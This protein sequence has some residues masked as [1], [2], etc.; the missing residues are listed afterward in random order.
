[1]LSVVKL[2]DKPS[3]ISF[4]RTILL[5]ALIAVGGSSAAIRD[6]DAQ[7]LPADNNKRATDTFLK[8][9]LEKNLDLTEID[10]LA[11]VARYE[12]QE[13]RSIPMP[14]GQSF[15]QK[16]WLIPVGDGEAP[17][18][19]TSSDVTNGPLRVLGCGIYG[20]QL[21]G[22]AM[23][24]ELSKLARMGQPTKH[25]QGPHGTTV[26]WSAQ[27][28]SRAPSDQTEVMMSRNIPQMPGV[29]V[30]LIYKIPAGEKVASP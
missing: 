1:M 22:T 15:R 29:S 28:G 20:P 21:D 9:C 4:V 17:I 12:V 11:T 10:R 2:T 8:W 24:V 6:A 5:L 16:N 30:N 3:E 18:L 25:P 14:N 27:V 13:D 19:L 7:L 26:W 23:E